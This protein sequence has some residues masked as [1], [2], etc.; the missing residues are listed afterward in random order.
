M[1]S[2]LLQCEHTGFPRCDTACGRQHENLRITTALVQFL[3]SQSRIPCEL[4]QSLALCEQSFGLHS[5]CFEVFP[6]RDRGAMLNRLQLLGP[7]LYFFKYFLVLS[8]H[9]PRFTR[10]D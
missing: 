3:V 6:S 4:S 10:H 1:I 2:L 8:A 7:M 9:K 5:S